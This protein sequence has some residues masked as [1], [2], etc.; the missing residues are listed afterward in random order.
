MKNKIPKQILLIC[1]FCCMVI[2]SW[3]QITVKGTVKSANGEAISGASILQKVQM[4]GTS[5]NADG[6][7]TL[8]GISAGAMLEISYVD[9][10]TTNIAA[11][12]NVDA[13]LVP[14]ANQLAEVEI[15]VDK[16]YGKTKRNAV[17]SVISSVKGSDLAG[18]PNTNLGSVLQGRAAGVQISNSGGA[19][20]P[21]QKIL[22]R[23]FTSLQNR[24]K[25]CGRHSG[26]IGSLNR[27]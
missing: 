6:S 16:G 17:T 1:I 23:G 8:S 21:T 4:K 25:I 20:P 24:T 18:M 5:S 12:A 22:I 27:R 10:E 3:A 15:F 19:N 9:I 11:A 26:K 14:K 13:V 7:F 2:T